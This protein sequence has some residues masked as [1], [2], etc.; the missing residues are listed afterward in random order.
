[1]GEANVLV[2]STVT[3]A[4]AQAKE[5]REQL[6]RLAATLNELESQTLDLPPQAAGRLSRAQLNV[7]RAVDELLCTDG[8]QGPC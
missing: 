4:R 5:V 3:E 7:T 8:G 1:M 2:E 6:R